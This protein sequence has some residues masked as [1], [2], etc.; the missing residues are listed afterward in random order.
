M[1]GSSVADSMLEPHIENKY[2][3]AAISGSLGGGIGATVGNRATQGLARFLIGSVQ[4]NK[5]GL[6]SII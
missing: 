3:R 2:V 5:L 6:P 4:N 1:M